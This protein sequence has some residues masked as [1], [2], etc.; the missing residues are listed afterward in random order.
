MT[1]KIKI[2][3][4][5]QMNKL[6]NQI[7]LNRKTKIGDLPKGNSAKVNLLLGLS[8]DVRYILMDEPFSGID[9]FSRE[10]ITELFC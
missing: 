7:K 1:S 9:I 5:R 4:F 8:L 10:Q 2:E 6:I 3:R